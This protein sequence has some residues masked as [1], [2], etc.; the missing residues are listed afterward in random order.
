LP[1]DMEHLR[2]SCDALISNASDDSSRTGNQ[3][4]I[5]LAVHDRADAL[6]I[7]YTDN[8]LGFENLG[9]LAD[10]LEESVRKKGLDRGLPLALAFGLFYPLLNMDI[11]LKRGQWVR[12]FPEYLELEGTCEE[13][14]GLR[15]TFIYG[16]GD[17]WKTAL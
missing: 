13:G 9:V 7:S 17:P 5:S 15:W 16:S 12:I 10:K 4:V 14:F 8:S 11:K 2:R 1:V 6:H 3:P